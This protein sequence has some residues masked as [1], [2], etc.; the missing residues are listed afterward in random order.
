MQHAV[1]E[2]AS[3]SFS[4][5]PW[6]TI[7]RVVRLTGAPQPT[8]KHCTWQSGRGKTRHTTCTLHARRVVFTSSLSVFSTIIY[9]SRLSQTPTALVLDETSCG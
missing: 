5:P 1:R 4:L 6:T 8:L 3:V 9:L 7:G 2:S